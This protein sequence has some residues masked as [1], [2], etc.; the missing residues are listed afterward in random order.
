M[1]ERNNTVPQWTFQLNSA[2]AAA[3]T[4]DLKCLTLK[5]VGGFHSSQQ[6]LK[7]FLLQ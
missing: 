7:H 1:A 4:W 3:E 2:P 5:V 6:F